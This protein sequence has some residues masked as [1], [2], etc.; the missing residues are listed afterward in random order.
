MGAQHHL[1]DVKVLLDAVAIVTQVTG[2]FPEVAVGNDGGEL[3]LAEV[4]GVGAVEL[5]DVEDALRPPCLLVGKTG[6]RWK[7]CARARTC[8][9]VR[10][11]V[12][13]CVQWC[14]CVRTGVCA[15]VF[16]VVCVCVCVGG[17]VCLHVR[18]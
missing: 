2:D 17:W 10:E 1:D 15:R 16:E 9:R 4:D 18:L 6:T 13:A 5:G 14:M 12:C 8:V 11:G 7:S 3:V